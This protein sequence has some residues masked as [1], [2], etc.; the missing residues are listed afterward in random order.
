MARRIRDTEAND[1]VVTTVGD[2]QVRA[3][4]IGGVAGRQGE[5]EWSPEDIHKGMYLRCPAAA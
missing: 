2:L 1:R 3:F 5:A 4:D